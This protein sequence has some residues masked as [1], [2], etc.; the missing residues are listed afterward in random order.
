MGFND[1]DS[2]EHYIIHQLGGVN[3]NASGVQEEK[4]GYG[5]AWEYKIHP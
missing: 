4:V 3:L 5:T 1:L 2:V